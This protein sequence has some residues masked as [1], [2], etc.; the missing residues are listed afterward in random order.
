[1]STNDP[2]YVGQVASVAGG[3]L[4][5]KLRRD[6]PT[7]LVLVEGES[8]RVGQIGGFFRIPLGY[9]HL[10]AV[11]AQVGADA[12][13]NSIGD[14]GLLEK[15]LAKDESLDGFRWMTVVLFGESVGGRFERGVGQ[16]PTVGDEIHFVTNA[17]LK[18]IYNYRPSSDSG[19]LVIGSV[20]SAAGIPARL[21]LNR[22]VSRHSAIVGSTGSGKSNLVSVILEALASEAYPSSRVL[23]IDPHGEYA[24][25]APKQSKVLG[26][27]P[28]ADQHQ[29][30]VPYWAL[31]CDVLLRITFGDMAPGNEAALRDRI[32]EMKREA[33]AHLTNPPAAQ[34]ITA[35]SPIPFSLK[36]LWFEFDDFERRTFVSATDKDAPKVPAPLIVNGDALTLKSNVYQPYQP[37][38]KEPIKNPHARSISKQLD[39]AKSRLTNSSYSFLY[40]P[41][42][43]YTPGIDGKTAAD[44]NELV[45]EWIGHGAPLSVIDVS[46][47][48]SDIA[49]DVVG[50]LTQIVYDILF[51]ANPL[52]VGG[53]H[54]PLLI[55][56]DEAHRFLPDRKGGSEKESNCHRVLTRI[57]KEGRKY[58]V[59]LMVVTQRP[60]E[61]DTTILSQCGTMISLRTTNPTDRSRVG[62]SFPDDLGGLVELLPALRTGEALL[63][64]EAMSV[65]SRVRI[66]RCTSNGA[67]TDPD[68]TE[69]WTRQERPS[70]NLYADALRKWRGQTKT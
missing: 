46:D 15:D 29:L 27:V 63:V 45:A 9:T 23:V 70:S 62:S 20:A 25:L 38:S 53:K 35:D 6:L 3:V 54:Q 2:T 43:K 48:P 7:T 61:I 1:M 60:S 67:G 4:R 40:D 39:F 28:A 11:C 26:I 30:V 22:L 33:A 32:Q 14:L 65:P 34:Q 19:G 5:V 42:E 47:L 16:Y 51:W 66:F 52:D 13:P 12:A 50:L 69:M 44:L 49:N 41:G 18:V 21:D 31:P 8:Y 10:Y 17:D 55:V 24:S 37:G 36:Q 64:G 57:A 58:G 59:G 68:V 56:I